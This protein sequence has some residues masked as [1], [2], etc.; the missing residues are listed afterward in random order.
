MD[1]N[2]ERVQRV[3]RARLQEIVLN[4]DHYFNSKYG[5]FLGIDPK[6]EPE[7]IAK[8]AQD[9]AKE[10]IT[11][12]D[13]RLLE[14]EQID[15][16]KDWD[17]RLTDTVMRNINILETGLLAT[18][19]LG[20]SWR[21]KKMRLL[22]EKPGDILE[23]ADGSITI[24]P[25][26]K[27]QKGSGTSYIMVN[28][29][30]VLEN[31]KRYSLD[32]WKLVKEKL[33]FKENKLG[34]DREDLFSPKPLPPAPGTKSPVKYERE[35]IDKTKY[36]KE[37]WEVLNKIAIRTF[38]KTDDKGRFLE[39]NDNPDLKRIQIDERGNQF[40]VK[41]ES[42]MGSIYE[43]KDITTLT[44]WARHVIDYDAIAYSRST[45]LFPTIGWYREM[46]KEQPPY[47]R[48]RIEYFAAYDTRL[49]N[50]LGLRGGTEGILSKNN[51]LENMVARNIYKIGATGIQE[52]KYGPF[53][54]KVADYIRKNAWAFVTP[55]TNDPGS[56]GNES[57]DYFLVQPMFLSTS[58]TDFNFWRTVTLEEPSAKVKD[59]IGRTAWHKRL[60]GMA[61]SELGLKNMDVNKP[62]WEVNNTSQLERWLGPFVTPHN[63][64]RA[65]LGEVEKMYNNANGLSEAEAGKRAGLSV[66][67]N[68]VEDVVVRT[69]VFNQNRVFASVSIG[70]AIANIGTLIPATKPRKISVNDPDLRG[71]LHEWVDTW[72][73]P[74]VNTLLDKP[75]VLKELENYSG[76]SA[77]VIQVTGLQT[78]R[79]IAS[80]VVNS[81]G[82]Q[83]DVAKSTREIENIYK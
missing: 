36:S 33:V 47:W 62:S 53:N 21:Y 78:G 40:I 71:K 58:L 52:Q 43:A 1:R 3:L 80:G 28:G 81:R 22:Q 50:S 9:V 48:P 20:W 44:F 64:N 54:Q 61:Y 76:T 68:E 4:Y 74:W 63:F 69:A 73:I 75:P 26:G 65:T 77:Q 41:R 13:K 82:Q 67:G 17:F 7:D 5:V 45:L 34:R 42:E 12:A 27:P 35:L 60:K 51:K 23:K 2:D 6:A 18:G 79:I 29:E 57:Q 8:A 83:A 70:N 24:G 66:R 15:A 38:I 56:G 11:N 72:I 30:M 55:W 31:D 46:W 39:G 16:N 32:F 37:E 10:I 14:W 59:H 25:D 49:L 19:D